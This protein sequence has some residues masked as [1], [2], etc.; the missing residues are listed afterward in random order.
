VRS[1]GSV[2]LEGARDRAGI[3][4]V[5]D[6][7]GSVAMLEAVLAPIA[8]VTAV[9]S[10]EAALEAAAVSEFAAVL[11]DIGLPTIDGF[12][13][14]RRLRAR[15]A[16]R[17]VPIIFLTGQIGDEQV[18]RGY[19]LGAADYLLKPFDPRILA[20]KVQVFVDL[21]RLR[22]ETAVLT[23]R[24]LHDS[25]TGLPNRTLFLDRLEHAL[26]R[27][28]RE[29]ALVG[30]VFVDLDGFKAIN[31]RLGHRAGDR[32]LIEVAARLQANIR[33]TDTAARFAGDEF[34]LL[35]EDL[36]ELHEIEFLVA[37]LEAVLREPYAAAGAEEISATAGLAVTDDPE[38]VA[39]ELIARADERMLARK[40]AR[41][42]KRAGRLAR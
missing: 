17:H 27:L 30:V 31:D 34:L 9:A 14:A 2:E 10:G 21:A 37:R 23:H 15:A 36:H 33:A 18:R 13:T 20:A 5:E 32:L 40:A 22:Q 6:D 12:E 38:A 35:V 29:P 19:E 3:L 42:T 4:V 28:A 26:T 11:L 41:H 16:T 8:D 39:E 7:L 25:L 1:R 24:S